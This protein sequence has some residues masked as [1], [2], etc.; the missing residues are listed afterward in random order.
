MSFFDSS[1]MNK[2]QIDIDEYELNPTKKKT[3]STVDD[4]F[5]E[6]VVDERH[7][8]TYKIV[9]EIVHDRDI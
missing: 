4:S 5:V 6:L 2:N 8:V 1:K 7:Y 9:V 3:F